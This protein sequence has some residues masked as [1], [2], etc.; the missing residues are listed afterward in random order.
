[1]NRINCLVNNLKLKINQFSFEFELA[2]RLDYSLVERYEADAC[3]AGSS[4]NEVMLLV[5]YQRSAEATL[6]WVP[7]VGRSSSPRLSQWLY[8]QGRHREDGQLGTAGERNRADVCDA[9]RHVQADDLLLASALLRAGLRHLAQRPCQQR[10]VRHRRVFLG[11]GEQQTQQSEV[12]YLDVS[13]TYQ[14]DG[15]SSSTSSTGTRTR[16]LRGISS[17]RRAR[18]RGP[19]R[20]ARSTVRA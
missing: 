4:E 15:E 2:I 10:D 8:P 12:P 13:A 11:L 3:V 5:V 9:G 16:R 6:R 7:T 19:S 14:S 20:S 17:R 1:M 18:L